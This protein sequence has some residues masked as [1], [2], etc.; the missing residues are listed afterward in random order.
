MAALQ[1]TLTDLKEKSAKIAKKIRRLEEPFNYI[2]VGA[3]VMIK[4]CPATDDIDQSHRAYW[5]LRDDSS[6]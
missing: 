2:G 4:V 6:L 1:N 5:R 3:V